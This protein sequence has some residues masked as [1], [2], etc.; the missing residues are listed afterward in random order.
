M[1]VVAVDW[2][3]FWSLVVSPIK[4]CL[5][6]KLIFHLGASLV[7]VFNQ[8]LSSI[9]CHPPSKSFSINS[10]LPSSYIYEQNSRPVV[11]LFWRFWWGSCFTSIEGFLWPKAVFLWRLSSSM[12]SPI[13]VVFYWR[14]S[15]IK[16]PLPLPQKV[17]FHKK[18][19]S[20]AS[21]LLWLL[22]FHSWLSCIDGPL[23]SFVIRRRLSSIN[24]YLQ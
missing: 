8:M 14:L 4:G 21:H 23:L 11:N 3:S 19:S 10:C 15:S 13:K 6:S 16:A 17:V 5:P 18:L 22:D 20:I 9:E 12:V 1:V 2:S 7:M 24:G